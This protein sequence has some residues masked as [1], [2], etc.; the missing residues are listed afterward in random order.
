MTQH[1]VSD[2]SIKSGLERLLQS[3]TL[4]RISL[5]IM[6]TNIVLLLTH[7]THTW[8]LLAS[9]FTVVLTCL[10]LASLRRLSI[11]A[12]NH[13]SDQDIPSVAM[14]SAEPSATR[15]DLTQNGNAMVDA[16]PG[17]LTADSKVLLH[18]LSQLTQSLY[19]SLQQSQTLGD[20]TMNALSEDFAALHA[21]MEQVLTIAK[22]SS[23]Q[24][25][26][27]DDHSFATES[28]ADLATV[29][30]ALADS[31][32]LKDELVHSIDDVSQAAS[33]LKQQTV[34]IQKIS[35]EITLLSLNASIEA[36]RAG[37]AGRGFAVV[38]E[39]VRELSDI[40]SEAATLIVTRMD[41]LQKAVSASGQKLADSQSKDLGLLH[42]V[43]DK[44]NHVVSGIETVTR[45]LNQ[46]VAA[47]D[48]SSSQVQH[49]VAAAITDFQFQDRVSQKLAHNISALEQLDQLFQQQHLPHAEQIAAVNRQLYASFTMQ[50]ERRTHQ[51]ELDNDSPQDAEMTF[52]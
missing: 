9:V 27:T 13:S 26:H 14:T 24:F 45:E 52:F 20:T 25:S 29:L 10:S 4:Q 40:T 41:N 46:T 36:A 7:Y 19:R 15:R 17:A 49:Q 51:G 38:A 3:S 12:T 22:A 28:R 6:M 1:V 23:K 30:Q 16:I 37:E 2:L 31:T 33:E 8:V 5:L 50:E 21:Q 43:E 47:L 39:R 48:Q 35:K 34:S 32:A 44:I 18:E 11:Q 42:Q